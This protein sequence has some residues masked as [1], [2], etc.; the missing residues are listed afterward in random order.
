MATMTGAVEETQTPPPKEKGV[1][2]GGKIE[3]DEEKKTADE[4][5]EKE[6]KEY[7]FTAEEYDIV[8]QSRKM[9]TLNKADEYSHVER[10]KIPPA[11]E[12]GWVF[13][14]ARIVKRTMKEAEQT[15]EGGGEDDES[16]PKQEEWWDIEYTDKEG[17]KASFLV[18]GN[19]DL[20]ADVRTK[21]KKGAKIH[22][23]EAGGKLDILD[24]FKSKKTGKET[25]KWRKCTIMAVEQYYVRIHYNNWNSKWDEW[26]HV[27]KDSGRICPYGEMTERAL[28]ARIAR[29]KK[30][31]EL[32]EERNKLTVVA[33]APDGS[34]LFRTVAHQVYGTASKHKKVRLECC[35]YLAKNKEQFK[36][37]VAYGITFKSYVKG[38][39]SLGEWGGDPEIR[40]ME[41]VYDRPFVIYEVSQD[42][43]STEP[44]QIHFNDLP[45]KELE[46]VEPIRLS[47]HGLNHYNSVVPLEVFS[48]MDEEGNF[49]PPERRQT[50]VIRDHRKKLIDE[51]NAEI[52]RIKAES[53][54]KE[55]E[56]KKNK[57]A[58]KKGKSKSTIATEVGSEEEKD[59][60]ESIESSKKPE[61]RESITKNKGP[62]DE[63]AKS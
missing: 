47:Y 33:M 60:K 18:T 37:F 57:K 11:P 50:T 44:R 20:V 41:E 8:D 48:Q 59:G 26:L 16:E 61:D 30:F 31:K 45:E 39:R 53:K 49:T 56:A 15:E 5:G 29:D 32:M 55:E 22:D 58:K 42:G 24:I 25:R 51:G 35:E 27:I 3:D 46:G 13:R 43:D 17:G 38:M 52:E 7:N 40:A 34:C 54:A 1:G 36:N 12:G 9:R 63:E 4:E 6:A 2:S 23:Y 28:R 10:N 62:L 14:P 19:E 21:A